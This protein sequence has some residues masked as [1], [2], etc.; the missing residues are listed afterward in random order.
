MTVCKISTTVFANLFLS[1]LFVKPT[2]IVPHIPVVWSKNMKPLIKISIFKHDIALYENTF[3]NMHGVTK[4]GR[5]V[6]SKV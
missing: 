5:Q 3:T 6:V 1:S 2:D 4:V